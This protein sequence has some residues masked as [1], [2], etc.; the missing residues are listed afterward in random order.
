MLDDEDMRTQL[1]DGDYQFNRAYAM[2]CSIYFGEVMRRQ[3]YYALFYPKRMSREEL[4]FDAQRGGEC[5]RRWLETVVASALGEEGFDLCYTTVM[6]EAYACPGDD[7]WFAVKEP[8]TTFSRGLVLATLRTQLSKRYYSEERANPATVWDA[9]TRYLYGNVAR[10]FVLEATNNYFMSHFNLRWY[11]AVVVQ[12]AELEGSHV[13]LYRAPIPLL[14]QPF[15]QYWVY[16]QHA[17]AQDIC[18]TWPTNN[19]YEA[20]AVWMHQCRRNYNGRVFGT[21]ISA[22]IARVLHD[23]DVFAAGGN[24]DGDNECLGVEI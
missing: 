16:D 6:D 1:P 3:Q 9:A 8:Q 14:I 23:A 15:S 12:H 4:Q 13:K 20:I 18:Y 2:M 17:Y 7:D 11:E 19:I 24:Q 5:V 21:D 22:C 10:D